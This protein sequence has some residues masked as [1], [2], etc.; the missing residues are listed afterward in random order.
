MPLS[1]A[2]ASGEK[3]PRNESFA[4]VLVFVLFVD[5]DMIPVWYLPGSFLWD[6]L[7]WN[8]PG[9]SARSKSSKCVYLALALSIFNKQTSAYDN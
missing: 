6:H 8:L 2:S 9:Y 7:V 1:T 5:Y 4:V 3:I